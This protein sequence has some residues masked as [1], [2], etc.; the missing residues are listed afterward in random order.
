MNIMYFS[1]KGFEGVF[2]VPPCSS[3]YAC[4]Y[5]NLV[6]IIVVVGTRTDERNGRTDDHRR[7]V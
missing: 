3:Y 7:R 1:R 6:V 5:V 2:V 4:F